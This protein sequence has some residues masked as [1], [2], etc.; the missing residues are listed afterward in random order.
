MMAVFPFPNYSQPTVL[1][2]EE[3]KRTP[4]S[5]LTMSRSPTNELADFVTT[6]HHF[7]PAPK[8][9]QRAFLH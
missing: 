7:V 6:G 9:F 8:L 3:P 1:C 4:L 2:C 5:Q